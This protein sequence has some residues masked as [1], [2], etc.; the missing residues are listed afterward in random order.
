[1][2][3]EMTFNDFLEEEQSVNTEE[4]KT[5]EVVETTVEEDIEEVQE[6]EEPVEEESEEAAADEDDSSLEDDEV[7]EGDAPEDNEESNDKPDFKAFAEMRVKNKQIEEEKKAIEEKQLKAEKLAKDLGYSNI[8]EMLNAAEK[9]NLEAQAKKEGIPV[10]VLERLNR[11][12][13]ENKKAKLE[14]EQV[15]KSQREAEIIGTLDSF[16]TAEKLSEKDVATV[17]NSLEA[18]GFTYESLMDLPS[19]SVKKLME[20]YKP[21]KVSQQKEIEKKEKLKKEIPLTPDNKAG[22]E[23]KAAEDELFAY[24]SGQKQDF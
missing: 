17:F 11:L 18:D 21:K 8:D 7:S 2:E 1:M 5:E 12:E 19:K 22:D 23:V 9:R 24:F 16:I 13:A 6:S 15:K 3:K 14:T 10:E 20:A 4:S